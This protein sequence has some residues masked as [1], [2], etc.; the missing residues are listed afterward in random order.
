MAL[1]KGKVALTGAGRGLGAAIAHGLA[2]QSARL[3]IT[4]FDDKLPTSR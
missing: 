3:I 2:E 1:L 4:D